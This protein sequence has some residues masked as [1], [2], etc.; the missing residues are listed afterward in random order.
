[1]N[2]IEELN[3]KNDDGTFNAVIE[4]SLGD[5]RKYEV[6][7]ISGK[8]EHDFEFGSPRIIDYG[9]YPINYGLIP[10]TVIPLNR[11][12]DGDPL[13]IL[14]LGKKIQKGEIIKFLPIGIIQMT[15]EGQKDDKIIGINVEE[16]KNYNMSLNDFF[17]S[18]YEKFDEIKTWF[19]NYKGFGV[20]QVLGYK[21][22]NDAIELISKAN[23]FYKKFGIKKF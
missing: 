7:K 10:N 16:N 22:A 4:I 15:D 3:A 13:D 21:D 8:L 9:S 14:I 1:M 23:Q 2:F 11:G 6:S 17:Y 20:T 5:N 12:G 19:E 18:N